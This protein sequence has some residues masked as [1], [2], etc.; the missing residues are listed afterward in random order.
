MLSS[1]SEYTYFVR[2]TKAAF[3]QD[4]Q[5]VKKLIELYQS[6][7]CLW[8]MKIADYKNI[9]MKKRAKKEIETHFD[10]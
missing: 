5:R 2:A 7:I 9:A 3:W 10:F 6:H 1:D 8:D 4:R